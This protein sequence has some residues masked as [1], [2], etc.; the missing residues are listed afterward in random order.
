[1][2]PSEDSKLEVLRD[3]ITH[4]HHEQ[5]S[6]SARIE[7]NLIYFLLVINVGGKKKKNTPNIFQDYLFIFLFQ[8]KIKFCKCFLNKKEQQDETQ[9][10]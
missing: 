8:I 5:K 3:E 1:M 4:L 7:Q 9:K 10:S 6:D 2:P